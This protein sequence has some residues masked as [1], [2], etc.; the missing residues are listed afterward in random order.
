MFG[1]HSEPGRR[2]ALLIISASSC[3][4]LTNGLQADN[5]IGWPQR[6]RARMIW[7]SQGVDSVFV[8]FGFAVSRDQD[9]GYGLSMSRHV[10]LLIGFQVCTDLAGRDDQR[11][12]WLG[13][14]LVLLL[15]VVF[16][17]MYVYE[18]RGS[19]RYP[20]SVVDEKI[21]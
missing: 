17:T 1:K 21:P 10:D 13:L 4:E 2:S 8:S 11:V 7:R 16:L 19:H 9:L 14:L 15:L 18:L 3:W 5:R 6:A 20:L 12:S